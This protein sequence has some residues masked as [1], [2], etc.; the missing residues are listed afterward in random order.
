MWAAGTSIENV[1]HGRVALPFNVLL[2]PVSEVLE[3]TMV[4]L[5][6]FPLHL[7]FSNVSAFLTRYLMLVEGISQPISHI[8]VTESSAVF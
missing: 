1:V 2:I 7:F 8:L 3:V 4:D 6:T 5:C